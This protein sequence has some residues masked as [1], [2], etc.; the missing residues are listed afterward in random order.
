[1]GQPVRGDVN[2]HARA[3][4]QETRNNMILRNDPLLSRKRK[5]LR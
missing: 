1:L 5:V 3:M 2:G 4:L